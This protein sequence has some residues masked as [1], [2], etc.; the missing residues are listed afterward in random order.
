M[1]LATDRQ[2][3]LLD[4]DNDLVI[5]GDFAFTS[6]V[7]GVAQT[8]RL[9]M[10]AVKGE[11]FLDLGDGVPYFD[12]L[13]GSRFDAAA[14]TQLFRSQL[15]AIP[16]VSSILAFG[17]NFDGVTRTL[18]VSWEVKTVFGDTVTDSLPIST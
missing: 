17:L 16:L 9:R 5:D 8:I 1:P 6:G 14:V 10:L 3:F 7:A 11:W 4:A 15:L 18:T 13:L 12:G 2:D